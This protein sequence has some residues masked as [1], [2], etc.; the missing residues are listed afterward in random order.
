[1]RQPSLLLA[2]LAPRH[3]TPL[4]LVGRRPAMLVD[5]HGKQQRVGGHARRQ[6]LQQLEARH[7]A[8]HLGPALAQVVAV[9]L[10]HNQQRPAGGGRSGGRGKEWGQAAREGGGRQGG[11]RA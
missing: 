9:L 7:A 6:L 8:Q 4:Q 10:R 3:D 5:G 11:R 1:M 2:R